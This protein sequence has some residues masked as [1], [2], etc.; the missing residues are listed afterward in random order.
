[1][2]RK[3]HWFLIKKYGDFDLGCYT[4]LLLDM[5]VV[6]KLSSYQFSTNQ[7]S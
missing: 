5:L 1:M 2:M 4:T 7:N 6:A 3:E